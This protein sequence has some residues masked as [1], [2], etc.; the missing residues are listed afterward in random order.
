MSRS[1]PILLAETDATS[2]SLMN[3][4]K[5]CFLP[6]TLHADGFSLGSRCPAQRHVEYMK[7]GIAILSSVSHV[8]QLV[9]SGPLGWF[10]LLRSETEDAETSR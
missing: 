9:H 8:I 6:T 7:K 10:V 2:T 5:S 4:P 1:L 3:A